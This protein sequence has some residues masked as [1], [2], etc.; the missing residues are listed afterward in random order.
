[1]ST[2]ISP[3]VPLFLLSYCEVE[4]EKQ[5]GLSLL[6]LPKSPGILRSFETFLRRIVSLLLTWHVYV[7]VA[8][9][10]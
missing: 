3:K 10:L 7:H 1:M 6:G 9:D 5:N 2:Y 4:S 8:V